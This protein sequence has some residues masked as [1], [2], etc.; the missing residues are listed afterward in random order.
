MYTFLWGQQNDVQVIL[1]SPPQNKIFQLILPD[2]VRWGKRKD[3]GNV[4]T[5]CCCYALQVPPFYFL[6][7]SQPDWNRVSRLDLPMPWLSWGL[8]FHWAQHRCAWKLHILN[9]WLHR[10]R[11]CGNADTFGL[12]LGRALGKKNKLEML[13]QMAPFLTWRERTFSFRC[14]ISADHWQGED[15][16]I[17]PLA[18]L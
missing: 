16:G 13:L 17:R 8:K 5:F 2:P 10:S 6:F 1:Q 9:W 11:S 14:S 3:G 12:E 7:F 18:Y 15:F 4:Q